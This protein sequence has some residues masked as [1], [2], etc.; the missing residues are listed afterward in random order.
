MSQRPFSYPGYAEAGDAREARRNRVSDIAKEL[1]GSGS[2]ITP[3]E[4]RNNRTLAHVGAVMS[5]LPE[6]PRHNAKTGALELPSVE[7]LSKGDAN[8]RSLGR[9]RIAAA[10]GAKDYDPAFTDFAAE[11]QRERGLDQDNL[12]DSGSILS[13]EQIIRALSDAVMQ[14]RREG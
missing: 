4:V 8:D 5:R 6:T 11:L 7:E 2:S 10:I 12:G 9:S 13:K 1:I 3:D 14:R